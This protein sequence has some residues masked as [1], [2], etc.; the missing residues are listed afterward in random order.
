MS[1]TI[2][3]V[4][5]MANVSVASV[6]RA[7]NGHSGVTA[8]T[9][10][11]IREVA[12]RLRYVPH[13]AARSLITRR[14]QT[15]GA[16]LPDLHGA[17]FSELIRGIDLA[18]RAHGLYMLV[19]SSHGDATEAAIALRAMQ[20]RVDGLL[21]MSP[22]ADEAFL[23]ENLP[24]VLPTVLI[25]SHVRSDRHAALDV[26]DYGGARIM[27]EHLLGLG[28]KRIAFIAGPEVNHDVQERCR[29]YR[30][31]L[32]A[33][34]LGDRVFVLPGDFTEES[35][36]HAGKQALAMVPRPDAIFAANDMMAIGCL[37]A[38]SEAK[39]RTPEDIAVAGFDDIPMARYVTPPLTT[40]RVRIAELGEA[41]LER[42]VRMIE[43]PED[44]APEPR[45]VVATELVVRASCGGNGTVRRRA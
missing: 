13:N 9:Q 6:S 42:L 39:V 17:F 22:H 31:A 29:G 3:D 11:R 26:D 2:K 27:T 30:E 7:L 1:V 35:G 41:A 16:L 20:G 43:A 14:T 12:A 23:D 8:E 38:L 24:I 36:Y 5:R 15:I 21:V 40:V 28:R 25:N 10:K 18:A 32:A 34:G 37:S 44:A 19:S 4:A 33:A 45:T